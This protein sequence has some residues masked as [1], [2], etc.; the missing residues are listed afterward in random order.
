MRMSFRK[1]KDIALELVPRS[2]DGILAEAKQS[3]ATFP[4]VTSVNVPEIRRL[5]IKSFE[6]SQLLLQSNIDTTPH[7][8]LIDRTEKDLLQKIS[9]LVE[10]GLKQVLL[11]GGDPAHDDPNFVPSGLTTLSAIQAVKREFP[12]LKIYAGLD[13]YRSSFR[14]ELDYAFAK[15]EAGCDG[16]YTQPFFSIGMLELWLEQLPEAEIWFGIAPV[17]TE[18]SKNYWERVNNVVFPPNFSFDKNFNTRLAR[19]LLVTISETQQRAYLMPVANGA[20][21]YLQNLFDC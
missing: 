9:A 15:R 20:I 21:E 2:L 4:F 5:P 17:Y 1:P 12:E 13:P 11:I 18:R 6:P 10:A 8:R 16:F 7:F 14:E 19:Q 3:L